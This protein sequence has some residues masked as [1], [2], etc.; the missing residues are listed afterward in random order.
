MAIDVRRS[1][2]ACWFACLLA[3]CGTPARSEV[4]PPEPVASTP[5]VVEV[6]YEVNGCPDFHAFTLEPPHPGLRTPAFVAASAEDPEGDELLYVWSATSGR[7][8]DTAQNQTIYHCAR[9]GDEVISV[10]AVDVRGC[11]RIL[12]IHVPCAEN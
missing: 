7:F 8:T 3:A 5:P 11:S 4:T 12:N 1:K 9:V 2:R 10:L 6:D